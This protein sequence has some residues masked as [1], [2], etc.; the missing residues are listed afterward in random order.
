MSRKGFSQ[1]EGLD[2]AYMSP[3]LRIEAI[4]TDDEKG[5][6]IDQVYPLWP[7]LV[8]ANVAD[9]LD[10]WENQDEYLD[11]TE[12]LWDEHGDDPL[13]RTLH[14]RHVPVSMFIYAA[15]FM[16]PLVTPPSTWEKAPQNVRRF[17]LDE[18]WDRTK[19][20]MQRYLDRFADIPESLR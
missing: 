12:T 10:I 5:A 1:L 19:D 16:I 17:V 6:F 7:G 3:C 18:Q 13:V 9:I 11:V 14:Q 4:M 20:L 15:M 2:V 8:G